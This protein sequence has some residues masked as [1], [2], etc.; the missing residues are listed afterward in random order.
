MPETRSSRQ[1]PSTRRV[2]TF[3]TF[4]TM[5]AILVLTR[6]AGAQTMYTVGAGG[7]HAT[8]QAAIDACPNSGCT[9]RLTDSVYKLPRELW[10]EGKT[11]LSIEGSSSLRNVGIR[12]RL[13]GD[14]SSLMGLAGT[15]TNPTDPL[16]PVGWKRWPVTCRDTV[17]GS[18]DSSNPY[19]TSGYQYNG[20]VVVV[21]S[22]DIRLEGL[23][24]DGIAPSYFF[25]RKIWDCLYDVVF[26]NIGVNLFHSK[27]VVLRDN[28][29]RHFF[30]A[31]YIQDRNPGGAVASGNR[32]DLQDPTLP[33]GSAYGTMG[34]HLVERN[35]IHDNWWAVYDEMEWDLGSTF[36]FN[37]AWSNFNPKFRELSNDYALGKDMAGGFLYV[38]D[39]P[40]AIHRIHNN[41]IWGSPLV[42]GQSGYKAGAQHLFYN[43]VVGG[44]EQIIGKPGFRAIVGDFRQLLTYYSEWIDH[45]VFEVRD[46][47]ATT[48]TQTFATFGPL[49]DTAACISD[50]LLPP[51]YVRLDTPTTITTI[52]KWPWPN[53]TVD[54]NG[55]V[56]GRVGGYPVT[57]RSPHATEQFPGGG[58]V[59]RLFGTGKMSF[60]ASTAENFWTYA[61]PWKS[62]SH[63][64]PGFLE[65]DWNDSLSI[66][67]IRAHGAM[68]SGWRG[69]LG[70]P[71]RGAILSGH[72]TPSIWALH[73]QEPIL[74][75][76]TNCFRIPLRTLSGLPEGTPRIFQVDAWSAPYAT[77]LNSGIQSPKRMS[78]RPLVDSSFVDG[79]PRVVC[80]DSTPSP[81][82][83]LRF[84]IELASPTASGPVLSEPAY[85]LSASPTAD[86]SVA[87]S[88]DA[89]TPARLRASWMHGSLQVSGLADGPVHLVVRSLDG[90]T[91][92]AGDL[93]A[94]R[95]TVSVTNRPIPAG[96]AIVSIEQDGRITS[97]K[98]ARFTRN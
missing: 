27:G 33:I 53:W 44:F 9:I 88:R 3:T 55:I 64:T 56:R 42:I 51:C 50:G 79:E 10:I 95:G 20:L 59:R 34:D 13:Y 25:N 52:V 75:A 97:T 7:S 36:R 66:R 43:N 30:S 76:G 58:L 19:S 12:P 41:T 14:S 29:L 57:T 86:Y 5:A 68:A 81:T 45:N 18:V 32:W 22:Q 78:I 16:R 77:S 31:I 6:H 26:G 71:D 84:Q 93:I 63:G 70:A 28:D 38:Q 49:S 4:A 2:A 61:I 94:Q 92:V 67:T 89:T 40:Q 17:G 91:L 73:S 83:G 60:D 87:V 46:T 98:V 39:V 54:S 11:H 82:A 96:T 85:F 37:R 1:F 65:P 24:L 90:R 69:P 21:R 72:E 47:V 23:T 80:L 62:T 35:D 8:I 15:A 74:K 48:E